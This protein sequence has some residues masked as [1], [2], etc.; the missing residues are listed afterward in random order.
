MKLVTMVHRGATRIGVL[1]ARGAQN[2]ILDLNRAQP[3]L[4]TDML[5]FLQAGESAFAVAQRAV[6]AAD[7]RFLIPQSAVTLLA[8]VPRPG[9][10]ICIGYNYR[11]HTTASG[12]NAPVPE[13][14]NFFAKYSNVVI[15]PDQPIIYP[16]VKVNLDYEGELAIIIG[17]RAKYVDEV[18]A[19]D[20]VAGYTIFNDVTAR[21]YQDRTSQW[22]L[23]KSFDTFGPMGPALVTRDEIPDPSHLDVRLTVNG[24]ERQHSNTC[25]MIFSIPFIIAYLSQAI[26]LEPGDVISTGTPSGIGSMCQPPVFMQPGDEVRVQIEKIGELVNTVAIEV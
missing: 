11:D 1:M 21:D 8:P 10:I 15:G 23:G 25:H 7:E 20:F 2:Y 22:T 14:P 12:A 18:R 13:Y 16:R 3:D 6:A 24:Q 19:L 9:K 4:P 5:Q 17:K 26:T